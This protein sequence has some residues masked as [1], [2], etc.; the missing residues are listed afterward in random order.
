MDA[1]SFL[2]KMPCEV[3][4]NDDC[5]F[6]SECIPLGLKTRNGICKCVP[7]TEEDSQGACVQTIHPFS[8]GPTIYMSKKDDEMISDSRNEELK[9]EST[10]PK[11]IQNLTVSIVSKEVLDIFYQTV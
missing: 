8:K 4:A 5:P 6:N 10:S 7:G 1:T 9:P 3:G 2:D 11:T